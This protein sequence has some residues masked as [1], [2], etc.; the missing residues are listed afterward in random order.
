MVA[1]FQWT[2]WE[3]NP[4]A[5]CLQSIPAPQRTARVVE[6]TRIELAALSLRT[7]APPQ[8]LPLV[9]EGPRFPAH[10]RTGAHTTPRSRRRVFLRG[11]R[12]CGRLESNQHISLVG[13]APYHWATSASYF[14]SSAQAHLRHHNGPVQH[15]ALVSFLNQLLSGV[16]GNRTRVFAMP[17]RRLP[18]GRRPLTRV[19][20]H[21]TTEC[22]CTRSDGNRTRTSLWCPIPVPPRALRIFSPTRSLVTPT[23]QAAWRSVRESD[24]SQSI[25][26][27]PATP[28]ASR[29]NI[30]VSGGNRTR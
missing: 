5:S 12:L 19:R 29:S 4:T 23:G 28:V 27:R 21:Y 2:V 6:K 15:I 1:N 24:P 30:G 13:G 20:Y 22:V 11:P 26:N 18:V 7:K 16:G 9:V 3:S 17:S 25:D 10:R 8:R 14:L